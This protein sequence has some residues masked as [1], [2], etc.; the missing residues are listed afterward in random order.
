[1][2]IADNDPVPLGGLPNRLRRH[3]AMRLDQSWALTRKRLGPTGGVD[4]FDGDPRFAVLT[5][6]FSTT[7]F[8]KLM[9]LTLSEQKALGLLSRI[10]VADNRSRDGG[11]LFL[12]GLS[13]RIDRL[14]LVENR[15]FLNHA[16]GM[17]RATVELDRVEADLPAAERSNLLLFCDPDVVFLNPEVLMDLAA[18]MVGHDGAFAGE[19]RES[20]LPYPEAQASFFVVRRD[21]YA[22]Q[23]VRPWVYHGFPAY[24]MQRSIWKAGLTVVDFPSNH[25]GHIL[26]RGRGGVE[27][28]RAVRA[29]SL[30]CQRRESGAAFHGGSGRGSGVGRDRSPSRAAP[31]G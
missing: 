2:T 29:P 16:R 8:L 30:L 31:T 11:Q 14:H 17:R 13:E 7:R 15:I 20:R 25:G 5:V 22:R 28:A 3:M 4:A 26:H 24:W 9:L 10:V 1:M 21:I 6:N 27:A 18:S 12:R 19:L 23:D